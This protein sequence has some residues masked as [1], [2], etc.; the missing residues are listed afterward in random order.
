MRSLI[1]GTT[2]ATLFYSASV[3]VICSCQASAGVLWLRLSSV[4]VMALYP[5]SADTLLRAVGSGEKLAPQVQKKQREGPH[6]FDRRALDCTTA[7]PTRRSA[8]WGS[9]TKGGLQSYSDTDV[10]AH[11]AGA[12][13]FDLS[14]WLISTDCVLC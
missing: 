1:I 11:T 2:T 5:A 4:G 3:E 10:Y 9:T 12:E 7:K 6:H 13:Q 14:T 8:P